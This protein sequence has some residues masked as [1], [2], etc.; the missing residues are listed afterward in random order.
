[1][2]AGDLAGKRA[3]VEQQPEFGGM[4]VNIANHIVHR[5]DRASGASQGF[6][7]EMSV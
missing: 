1:M 4:A 6:L 2:N 3:P 5:R 7:R